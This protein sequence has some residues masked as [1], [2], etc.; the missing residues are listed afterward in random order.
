M[1]IK[2]HLSGE[3]VDGGTHEQVPQS[4]IGYFV[5]LQK[6]LSRLHINLGTSIRKLSEGS[7][8]ERTISTVLSSGKKRMV[9]LRTS[10][11]L[12]S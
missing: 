2:T 8:G 4:K 11:A 6:H 5:A 7:F 9:Y 1:T 3:K 12:G 10:D